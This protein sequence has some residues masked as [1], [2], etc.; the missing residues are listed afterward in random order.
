MASPP[1][2]ENFT[3]RFPCNIRSRTISQKAYEYELNKEFACELLARE[4]CCK[5]TNFLLR[6][7]RIPTEL[8]AL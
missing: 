7:L 6:E 8:F 4:W 3:F 1:A 5:A 2:T